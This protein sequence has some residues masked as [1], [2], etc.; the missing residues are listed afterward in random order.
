MDST[1]TLEL[2]GFPSGEALSLELLLLSFNLMIQYSS[3]RQQK[4]ISGHFL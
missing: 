4:Q 1:T 3:E 2:G